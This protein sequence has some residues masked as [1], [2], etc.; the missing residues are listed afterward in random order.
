MPKNAGRHESDDGLR[1][2]C[3]RCTPID[4]CH[5]ATKAEFRGLLA[6][7]GLLVPH[8]RPPAE[9]IDAGLVGVLGELVRRRSDLQAAVRVEQTM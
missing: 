4:C 6:L 7:L 1:V 9:T 5:R 3:R 2:C 8:D